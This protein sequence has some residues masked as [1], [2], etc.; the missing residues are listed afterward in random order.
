MLD[1]YI[2]R[3]FLATFAF[4]IAIFCVVA[5]V[6]DLME[7]IDRLI[8]NEAPFWPTVLYYVGFCFNLGNLLSGFIVFLTVIWF[9]SRMAQRT[10]VIAML[11]G[12]MSYRRLLRPYFVAS[13]VLVGA[14]L[15]VGHFILPHAN[16]QK[17]DFEVSHVH[18]NFHITDQHMYRELEPGVVAYFRSITFDRKTGYRFQLER[19]GEDNRLELNINAAKANWI[20]DDSTWRLTNARIREFRPDG[21]EKMRF[22]TRLDTAIQMRIEDFGQRAQL[23]STMTT[24]ELKRHIAIEQSRGIPVANLQL[25]RFGRTSNAFSIFVLMLIGV[26]VASRKQRGGMGVHL[27]IA[28]LVG[29]TFVFTGKIISVFAASAVLP[30]WFPLSPTQWLAI[31][32]W[33]PN[34]LF[35]GL[36]AALYVRTPK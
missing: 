30:L 19:W 26:T 12:G 14:S 16:Q 28:V 21:T 2:I 36:G 1:R 23:V 22:L 24:P 7:N 25:E 27:F 31:A 29:F 3:K 8:V 13:A 15:A 6:F 4:M 35:A 18:V 33:L 17:V 10:E 20:E 5:V 32:A 9:T 34:L 11:S